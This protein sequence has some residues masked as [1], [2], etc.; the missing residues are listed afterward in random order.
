[1]SIL[2]QEG[3]QRGRVVNMLKQLNEMVQNLYRGVDDDT[4]DRYDEFYNSVDI[5]SLTTYEMIAY[6]ELDLQ[7]WKAYA[8]AY[9]H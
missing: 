9:E 5:E 2:Y 7:L 4:L 1:M 3:K 6:N 8:T